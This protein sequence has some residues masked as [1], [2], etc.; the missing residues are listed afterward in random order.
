MSG[1][2]YNWILILWTWNISVNSNPSAQKDCHKTTPYN[3]PNWMA[4]HGISIIVS[5]QWV[6]VNRRD[7]A[8]AN[9]CALNQV[10][11]EEEKQH[12]KKEV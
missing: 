9:I 7:G 1:K 6:I 3:I 11:D 8:G 12:S 5:Y 4:M 2:Q 10:V